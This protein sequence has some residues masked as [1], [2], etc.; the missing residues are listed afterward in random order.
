MARLI[1]E[2]GS[3]SEA[4]AEYL[5][6]ARRRQAQS[7]IEEATT[8]A[9]RALR[10]DPSSREA[11]ELIATLHETL[12]T[13]AQIAVTGAGDQGLGAG[14][15]SPIPSP[16]SLAPAMTGALRSQQFAIEQ[17]ITLAQKHQEAGDAEAAI[18]Q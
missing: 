15:M 7:R 13:A 17:I 11:K 16:Q 14:N 12:S 9:E 4:T 8:Y 2:S 3:P 10:I 1:E 6:L 5:E 18:E